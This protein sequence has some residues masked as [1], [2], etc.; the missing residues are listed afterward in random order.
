MKRVGLKNL[1]IYKDRHGVLRC[2]HRKA[3]VAIDLKKYP[4]QSDEFLQ[5]Y[6]RITN[7]LHRSENPKSGCLG[8]LIAAY[9]KSTAFI[10]LSPRT[11][12]DYNRIFNYL[13]PL[14]DIDLARF[15]PPLCVKIRD[16]AA[17]KMGRKWGNYTK[18]VLS[19]LFSWA[20]EHGFMDNNPAFR[21]KQIK[22]PRN[23]PQANRPWSDQERE[24]VLA[25]LPKHMI[26][27]MMLMMFCGLDPKDVLTL[28]QS[29]IRDGMIDTKRAKTAVP[30]WIPLPEPVKKVLSYQPVGNGDQMVCLN[31]KGKNWTVNGFSASWRKIKMQLLAE[32][33]VA[34]GLTLK[35]LRHTVATILAEMGYDDRTIADMLGQK[36]LA[37]AQHYSN[38]ANRSKKLSKVVRQFEQEVNE[39]HK[40]LSTP[41]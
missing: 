29:A 6:V 17:E 26:L 39:R 21:I 31:S 23:A 2:Y 20:V 27:P 16:K 14:K 13:E 5:E 15:T 28:P 36:T 40:K 24:N 30:V 22:R 34:E 8:K 1:K 4:L 11:Q 33:K 19:L 18:T 7:N 12:K 35:G 9:K 41:R 38:R 10:E 3:G 25:A 37:M 32:H